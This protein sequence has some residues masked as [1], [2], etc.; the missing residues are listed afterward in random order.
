MSMLI[1]LIITE[2]VTAAIGGLMTFQ[3]LS[4]LE[5]RLS[6]KLKVDY[7]HDLTSDLPFSHSLDFA[8]Y[9]V[10]YQQSCSFDCSLIFMACLVIK[11]KSLIFVI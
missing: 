8:Q 3:I 5:E 4:D 10:S 11:K 2:L 6:N 7:G 1:A 9:K